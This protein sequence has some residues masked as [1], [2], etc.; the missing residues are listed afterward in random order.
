MGDH[1]GSSALH[2][3][4][5]SVLHLLL[6]VLIESA[7][8]LIEKKDA[9]L[10]DNGSGDG[11]SLLLASRELAALVAGHD[12]ETFVE[13]LPA[14]L[15]VRPGVDEIS[16]RLELTFILLLLDSLLKNINE[17]LVLL[18]ASILKNTSL[19]VGA[20]DSLEERRWVVIEGGA[21]LLG[22]NEFERVS[23][24]SRVVDLLVRSVELS[25]ENVLSE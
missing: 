25:V 17:R 1:N 23:N 4:V 7:S 16:D 8:G 19:K 10:A 15:G 24:G 18:L 21:E 11:D 22:L 3:L 13:L 20:I 9:R 5:E 12:A 6:A 14:L 2:H